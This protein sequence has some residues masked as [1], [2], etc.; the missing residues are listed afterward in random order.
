VITSYRD[1]RVWQIGMDLVEDVYCLTQALPLS[2]RF[3]LASQMQRAAVSVPANIAE[4]QARGYTGEYLHHLAV[5]CGSIAELLTHLE[6]ATRLGYIDQTQAARVS[7][8]A[9]SI[10]RQLSA[11]RTAL[12]DRSQRPKS[13][14]PTPNSR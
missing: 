11:L 4:G 7:A 1:L 12:R 9:E 8:K 14:L 5:A 10:A 3:G 2:E 13:Q 6:L